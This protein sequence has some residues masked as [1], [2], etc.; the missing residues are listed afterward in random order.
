VGLTN[1]VDDRTDRPKEP[2][3]P[4][5]WTETEPG[6]R[7]GTLWEPDTE[8]CGTETNLDWGQEHG[9]ERVEN[10]ETKPGRENETV[11]NRDRTY[12]DQGTEP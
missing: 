9:T 8:P 12:E 6:T 3:E 10:Q 1:L 2:T 4:T 11:E 7:T 5:C